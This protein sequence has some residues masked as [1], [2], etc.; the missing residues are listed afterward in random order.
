MEHNTILLKPNAPPSLPNNV[1]Q[2]VF[3]I[4]NAISSK[5]NPS[6]LTLLLSFFA[7]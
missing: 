3:G 6:T 7:L 4:I 2:I 5:S 1:G